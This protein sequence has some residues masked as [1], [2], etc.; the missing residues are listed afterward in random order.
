MLRGL[1]SLVTKVDGAVNGVTSRISP[2]SDIRWIIPYV[3]LPK[4]DNK[5]VFD[6]CE[7]ALVELKYPKTNGI[8]EV[9]IDAEV[10]NY[11][12]HQKLAIV[13]GKIVNN[14]YYVINA[15]VASE[16]FLNGY[17][18][19]SIL[20]AGYQCEPL[21]LGAAVFTLAAP[22]IRYLNAFDDRIQYDAINEYFDGIAKE[23]IV[24]D[25]R[26]KFGRTE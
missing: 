22:F 21:A 11:R 26:R 6:K 13:D 10:R 15:R 4:Y 3:K 25:V 23:K 20:D 18:T 12:S 7:R 9:F 19:I 14:R 1:A 8:I 2:A 16:F 24:Q 17:L 5:E